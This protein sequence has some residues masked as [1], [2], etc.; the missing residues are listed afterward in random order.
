MKGE[1]NFAIRW[2]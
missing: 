2:K 1:K